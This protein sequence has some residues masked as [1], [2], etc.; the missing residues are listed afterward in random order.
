[1]LGCGS[2]VVREGRLVMWSGV[3]MVRG[4]WCGVVWVGCGESIAIVLWCGGLCGIKV[5]NA[6][7]Y[8]VG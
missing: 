7:G 8:E 2:G 3:G 6:V 5:G 1:M 4:S